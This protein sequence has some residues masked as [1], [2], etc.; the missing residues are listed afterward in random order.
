MSESIGVAGQRKCYR[1]A[2]VEVVTA[3][4]AIALIVLGVHSLVTMRSFG[5]YP[6]GTCAYES[7]DLLT[8]GGKASCPLVMPDKY[9]SHTVSP[10]YYHQSTVHWSPV[11]LG[12][13]Y[14]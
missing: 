6:S 12:V 1:V 3:L 7:V 5:V 9:N 8:G 10:A 4:I 13:K 2:V 14:E 11:H